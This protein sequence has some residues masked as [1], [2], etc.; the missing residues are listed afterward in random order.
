MALAID[1]NVSNNYGDIGSANNW[2]LVSPSFSTAQANELL[3]AMV[4]F[5]FVSGGGPP[6]VSSLTGA[7]LTWTKVVA[8]ASNNSDV[9]D[10]EIWKAFATSLLSNVTVTASL[11]PTTDASYGDGGCITVMSFTGADMTNGIGA[12][13]SNYNA[14][15]TASNPSVS[16]TTTA[17]NS[18]VI[19]C[20][21]CFQKNFNLTSSNFG[22]GQS[23][24]N[25]FNNTTDNDTSWAQMT[26]NPVA[27]S[28]TQVTLSVNVSMLPWIM[29]AV[30]V[31]AGSSGHT[32][33]SNQSASLVTFASVAA[34]S[35]QKMLNSHP[36]QPAASFSRSAQKIAAA[37]NMPL[38]FSTA[39][40]AITTL[41]SATTSLFAAGNNYVVGK[42]ISVLS[43]TPS[44]NISKGFSKLPQASLLPV[45][46]GLPKTTLKQ[47]RSST[48][49]PIA[50][51]SKGIA[52][53]ISAA[54]PL[55]QSSAVK[56]V[57]KILASV[58]AKAA[59]TIQKM[60]SFSIQSSLSV[61]NATISAVKGAHVFFQNLSGS[62]ANINAAL[63]K[64]AAIFLSAVP[65]YPAATTLKGSTKT[66]KSTLLQSSARTQKSSGKSL[67][68][69]S[70]AFLARQTKNTAKSAFS[71]LTT[72]QAASN[73][74]TNY[75]LT[76]ATA[77]AS[78]LT[79]AG[80]FFFQSLAASLTTV[81]GQLSA[82]V[83]RFLPINVRRF[84]LA[85]F[86]RIW[87]I[88]AKPHSWQ[89]VPTPRYWMVTDAMLYTTKDPNSTEDFLFDWTLELNGDTI[90]SSV[91][92]APAGITVVSNSNISTLT[93]ARISGGTLGQTYLVQ[94]T[95][96]LASGQIKTRGIT[97]S[98]QNS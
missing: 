5:G 22:S 24:V 61:F 11:H 95:V 39:T 44:G 54:A 55:F 66:Q 29:A 64:Q 57:S 25:I 12:S 58:P 81:S 53:L 4:Y 1:V 48:S 75:A 71:S 63:L 84:L 96:T 76:A 32:Y 79:G 89:L 17:A 62:L 16:I 6:Y 82:Q 72:L 28:G 3:I 37:A 14:G 74:N 91:W 77:T 34:K 49:L 20:G 86:Q 7:G 27:T 45:S 92:S 97:I 15:S 47:H 50:S 87:E 70:Q 36:L 43:S 69:Q 98:I 30:E 94:N 41:S 51:A 23:P 40:K 60:R 65:P 59:A 52:K 38:W 13:N 8:Q 90:V 35:D 88:L 80:R 83:H 31:L 56:S 42:Y 85:P 21:T 67:S 93:T 26:T 46:A 9:G 2:Q 68:S 33:Q 73:K 18:L 19:G 10:C 78:A